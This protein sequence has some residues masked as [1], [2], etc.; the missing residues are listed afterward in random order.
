MLR[1]PNKGESTPPLV[2]PKHEGPKAESSRQRRERHEAQV[3]DETFAKKEKTDPTLVRI[4]TAGAV[5]IVIVLAVGL[6]WPRGDRPTE[7]SV[8]LP[9][10]LID[11]PEPEPESLNL[12]TLSPDMVATQLMP[13]LQR[14]LE[15][16]TLKEASMTCRRPTRTLQRMKHFHGDDYYPP[17]LRQPV[18]ELPMT[19]DGKWALITIEDKEFRKR[20]IALALEGSEWKVDWESWAGWSEVDLATAREEK[21]TEPFLVRVKV[22]PIDYYNFEFTD[23][24]KWSAYRLSDPDQVQTLYGYV[25]SLGETDLRL[26]PNPGEKDLPYTLRIH[27]PENASSDNQVIIDEIVAAGWHLR[28]EEP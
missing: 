17:G 21:P 12:D 27:F 19:R 9:K 28:E 18:W 11:L 25:A 10:D 15:A 1:L 8:V 13:V 23:D 3:F 26:K 5:T 24:S 22:E 4:I 2:L 7:A 14:F 20:P 6:L 16:P